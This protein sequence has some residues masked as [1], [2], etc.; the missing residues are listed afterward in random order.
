MAH[1]LI[2]VLYLRVHSE[3]LLQPK[4]NFQQSEHYSQGAALELEDNL[5][6][7]NRSY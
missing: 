2:R 4:L 6:L 7:E 5:A 1:P 3:K